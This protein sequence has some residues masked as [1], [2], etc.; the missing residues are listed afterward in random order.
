MRE[1][2]WTVASGS[3]QLV[4]LALTSLSA[5]ARNAHGGESESV[6]RIRADWRTRTET[7]KSFQYQCGLEQLLVK[8][9]RNHLAHRRAKQGL[10]QLDTP[11]NDTILHSSFQFSLSGDKMA[12]SRDGEQWDNSQN[13]MRT[14]KSR[15][16][17]D[18]VNYRMLV[19]GS[20]FPLGDLR[21]KSNPGPVADSLT[22]QADAK[23]MWLWFSPIGWLERQGYPARGMKISERHGALGWL[24]LRSRVS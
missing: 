6:E 17:F 24:R 4:F 2:R 21:D 3:M 14:V 8:G 20:H 13:S 12:Y 9:S 5:L 22:A 1:S 7:I 23:A 15:A 11:K 16:A 10:P 18:D 19:Q